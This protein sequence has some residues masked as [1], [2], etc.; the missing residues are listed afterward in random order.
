VAMA[1][2]VSRNLAVTPYH[3]LSQSGLSANPNLTITVETLGHSTDLVKKA[4]VVGEDK[5]ANIAVIQLASET[6]FSLPEGLVPR[7]SIAPVGKW[8]SYCLPAETDTGVYVSGVVGG[9][10][11]LG[12]DEYQL[13]ELDT[14]ISS[15]GGISGAP[16]IWNGQ[17]IGI[18]AHA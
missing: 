18:L 4:T 17:L 3:V 8:D 15:T 10:S 2:L 5:A 16:I 14:P 11:K 13:L 12:N 6:D 1:S 9:A 7:I